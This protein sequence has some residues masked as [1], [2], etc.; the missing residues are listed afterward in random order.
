MHFDS[1]FIVVSHAAAKVFFGFLP[2][3]FFAITFILVSLAFSN[4]LARF[5]D[6]QFRQTGSHV[7]HTV[8]FTNTC[9]SN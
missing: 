2:F 7:N 8:W 4:D 5:P 3:V 6:R 9:C 1:Q